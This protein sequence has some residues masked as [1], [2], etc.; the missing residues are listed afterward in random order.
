M[1]EYADQWKDLMSRERI[2]VI[3]R[4]EHL[5]IIWKDRSLKDVAMF[6]H[7]YYNNVYGYAIFNFETNQ[8]DPGAVT[9]SIPF[10]N[11]PVPEDLLAAITKDDK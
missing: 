6:E 8:W 5:Q 7:D 2:Q 9:L 1:S 3:T 4:S 11:D 10:I